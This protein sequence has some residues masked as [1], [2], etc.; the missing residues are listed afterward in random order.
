LRFRRRRREDASFPQ[1]GKAEEKRVSPP[2]EKMHHP[3][4]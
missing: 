1:H 2:E 3:G 4:E